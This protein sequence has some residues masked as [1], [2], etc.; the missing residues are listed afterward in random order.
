MR[1]TNK[2]NVGVLFPSKTCVHDFKPISF[3]WFTHWKPDGVCPSELLPLAG[4]MW[5]KIAGAGLAKEQRVRK[6]A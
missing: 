3:S 4:S 2:G 1:A 6:A 5:K